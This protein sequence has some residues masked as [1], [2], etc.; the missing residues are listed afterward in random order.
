MDC[1]DRII[2]VSWRHRVLFTDDVFAPTNPVLR[3][4]LASGD[5]SDPCKV[6]FVIDDALR[7]ARPNILSAISAYFAAHKHALT[8]V[9]VPLL[10]HGGEQAKNCWSNV[11]AL[12]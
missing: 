8:L 10:V 11:S 9:S 2:Q 3:D 5:L 7:A 6:L 4:T 1:I 12:H